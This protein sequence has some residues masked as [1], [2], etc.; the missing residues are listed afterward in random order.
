MSPRDE[1]IELITARHGDDHRKITE[2][3]ALFDS[4]DAPAQS[5]MILMEHARH[6]IA[7]RWRTNNALRSAQA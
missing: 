7:R 6:K 5:V 4:Y 1:Y 3:L 2:N